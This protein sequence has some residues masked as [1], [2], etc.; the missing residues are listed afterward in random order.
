MPKLDGIWEVRFVGPNWKDERGYEFEVVT[1][2]LHIA[3][4]KHLFER[5]L[6]HARDQVTRCKELGHDA[7]PGGCRGVYYGEPA[8]LYFARVIERDSWTPD[9]P[10]LVKIKI[11]TD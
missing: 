8:C 2:P 10:L 3:Y 11:P 6:V 1:D 4:Y 9:K 7:N 5:G